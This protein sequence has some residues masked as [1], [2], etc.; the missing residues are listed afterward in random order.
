MDSSSAAGEAG[1]DE[2]LYSRQLFVM[3]ERAMRSMAQSRV[4]LS[5]LSGLGETALRLAASPFS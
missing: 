5:G 4:F 3:G 1:I 2:S